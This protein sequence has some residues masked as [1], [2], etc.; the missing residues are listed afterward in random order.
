M[1]GIWETALVLLLLSLVVLVFQMIFFLLQAK[2]TARKLNKTLEI[3]NTN[4]PE[5]MERITEISRSVSKTVTKVEGAAQ[6]ITEI[7]QII[8]KEIK[9]PLKNVAQAVSTVLQLANRVFFR[10]SAK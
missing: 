1:S 6:D 2:D 7:E 4:L 10:K 8:S 9:D 5:V 3:V